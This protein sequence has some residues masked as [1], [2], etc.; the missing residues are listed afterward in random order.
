MGW[1]GYDKVRLVPILELVVNVENIFTFG[2]SLSLSQGTERICRS[3]IFRTIFYTTTTTTTAGRSVF[4]F[5]RVADVPSHSLKL[6][7]IKAR[8]LDVV[9][10]A[11]INPPFRYD[12]GNKFALSSE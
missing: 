1:V 7:E 3:F 2:L 8:A 12:L 5:K 4:P 6:I 9:D 11:Q 10:M